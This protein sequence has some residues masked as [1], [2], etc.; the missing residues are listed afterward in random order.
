MK[1]PVNEG[2]RWFLKYCSLPPLLFV[3]QLLVLKFNPVRPDKSIFFDDDYVII[4]N[5]VLLKSDLL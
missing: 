1:P 3:S 4:K 2:K 5:W